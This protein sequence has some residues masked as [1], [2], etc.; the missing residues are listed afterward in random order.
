MKVLY[1]S[2]GVHVLV[3]IH[4]QAVEGLN[5][6]TN[7]K[8][9]NAAAFNKCNQDLVCYNLRRNLR[10]A[11]HICVSVSSQLQTVVRTKTGQHTDVSMSQS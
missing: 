7:Y 11:P 9:T 8:H 1:C 5:K 3:V 6:D 4:H 2:A 10:N